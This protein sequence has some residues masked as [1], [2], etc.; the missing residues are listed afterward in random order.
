MIRVAILDDGINEGLYNIGCLKFTTEITPE[1]EFVER[2]G[3]N[4]YLPSHGTTC[5][6]I[7]KKYSPDLLQACF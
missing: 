4:K 2:I 6:A 5:G 1:I 7:I 3:Y